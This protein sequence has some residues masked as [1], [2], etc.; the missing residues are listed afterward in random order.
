MA[1]YA[2]LNADNVVIFVTPLS[3]EVSLTDGVDDEAKSVAYLESLFGTDDT[4]L[5]TSYNHN[6]RGHYTGVGETYDPVN[7]IFV[8]P[9]SEYPSWV[10]NTTTGL[11]EAPV[12]EIKG[13]DWNEDT[14]AWEQPPKPKNDVD[15]EFSSFT[16]QTTW[17]SDGRERPNGCWS[18]PV[19]HPGTYIYMDD[20]ARI[21]TAPYIKWDEATLTWLEET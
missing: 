3:D 19:A 16:W 12:P 9:P 14:G 5:R 2:R 10:L 15:V 7:D 1:H 18:P 17:Q 20:G 11:Y 21:Y 8:S 6:I 4:W 13:Y